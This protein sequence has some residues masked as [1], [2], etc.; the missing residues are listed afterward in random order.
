MNRRKAKKLVKRKW[1]L[2]RLGFE[3]GDV[4]SVESGEAEE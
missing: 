4:S 1:N 3:P 2:E